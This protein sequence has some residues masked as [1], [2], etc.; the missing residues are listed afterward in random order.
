MMATTITITDDTKDRLAASKADDDTWDDHLNYLYDELEAY[1][2]DVEA[3]AD[4]TA[5][6]ARI[7]YNDDDALGEIVDRLDRLDSRLDR[8]ESAFS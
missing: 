8:L 7:K 3:T 4:L 2:E 5:L 1:A 6:G